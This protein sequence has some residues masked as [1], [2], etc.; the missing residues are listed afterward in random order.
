MA[1][2]IPAGAQQAADPAK[3]RAAAAEFDAGRRAFTQEDFAAAAPHFENAY[4]DAPTEEAIRL[5]MRSWVK[6]GRAARAATLAALALKVHK[7]E[8][9]T[10]LANAILQEQA[11]ALFRANI[12]CDPACGIVVDGRAVFDTQ[13][14][15]FSVF[16]DPGH[17]EISAT[18]QTT[19][20]QNAPVEAVAGK[21]VDIEFKK[22]DEPGPTPV[23]NAPAPEKAGGLPPSVAY[24]G[25]GLTAVLAGVTVWSA[26]DTKNNPG[27]D[28]VESGC[29][30]Q[31]DSCSLYQD[32]LSRQR[33][34]NILIG[35]SAGVAVTTAVISLI[36]TDWSSAPPAAPPTAKSNN[37]ASVSLAPSFN[38]GQGFGLGA[39]G[40]F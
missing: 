11:P 20:N 34:T 25:M 12:A 4:R 32:G 30:N 15:S 37:P 18:W 3:I 29:V 7:D 9:T 2:G 38:V 8:K 13:G 35:A 33:R 31:G 19:G 24:I 16:L 17:H 5:A 23:P 27:R 36:Y 10:T 26:I 6:A 28:A 40:R 22:K 21:F 1:F 14:M 39:V